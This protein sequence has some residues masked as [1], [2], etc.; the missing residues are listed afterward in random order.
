[1]SS[2][3]CLKMINTMTANKVRKGCRWSPALPDT[4]Y[5][6]KCEFSYNVGSW[7]VESK[8]S[9]GCIVCITNSTGTNKDFIVRIYRDDREFQL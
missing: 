3:I 4:N 5:T 8:T 1:M 7:W 9:T 6:V 2:P